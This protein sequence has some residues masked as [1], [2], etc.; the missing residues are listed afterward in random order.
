MNTWICRKEERKL[1]PLGKVAGLLEHGL[2]KAE[3]VAYKVD[4]SI[5]ESY[6]KKI[7]ES[8]VGKL[9]GPSGQRGF[10]IGWKAGKL[11]FSIAD[12]CE[13]LTADLQCET[14]SSPC[15]NTCGDSESLTCVTYCVVEVLEIL[16]S[17]DNCFENCGTPIQTPCTY[18]FNA[19]GTCPPQT[20]CGNLPNGTITCPD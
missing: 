8:I 12:K 6:A 14:A 19:T 4:E 7:G 3:E 5:V 13:N 11:Y 16:G 10:G 15:N 2:P 9:F 18:I 20:T 1:L 17:V